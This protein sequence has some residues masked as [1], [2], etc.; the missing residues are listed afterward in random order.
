MGLPRAAPG[1]HP[2]GEAA[3]A[4]GEA[5]PADAMQQRAARA[6]V[7]RFADK[8]KHL[9]QRVLPRWVRV[10]RT[11]G[12]ST[13]TWRLSER[14]GPDFGPRHQERVLRRW[15]ARTL[16]I[17]VANIEKFLDWASE[18]RPGGDHG[19]F[20]D[21]A[22][23]VELLVRYV[24]DLLDGGAA[25]TMPG[26]RLQSLRFLD[27]AAGLAP[28][29][30]AGEVCVQHLALARAREAPA[31]AR[32]PT[33]YTAD[34]IR[35]LERAAATLRNP[36]DRVVIRTELRK[37]FAALRNDA[38]VWDKY[39]NWKQEGTADGGCLYGT[40][41]KTKATEATATR[42]RG[43]MPWIAPLRGIFQPPSGW[44]HGYSAD[45]KALGLSEDAEFAAKGIGLHSARRTI[46]TW[47]GSSGIFT[48]RELEVLG[49]HRSAGVGRVVCAC[50]VTVMA[51]PVSKLRQLLEHIVQGTFHPDAPAGMQWRDGARFAS[52]PAAPAPAAAPSRAEPV[53][54]ANAPA[55]ASAVGQAGTGTAPAPQPTPARSQAAAQLP[56]SAAPSAQVRSFRERGP[57]GNAAAH[58]A[59]QQEA[60]GALA[61]GA[62]TSPPAAAALLQRKERL[63]V[64]TPN[65]P[66]TNPCDFAV[67]QAKWSLQPPG[68]A[69]VICKV[70]RSRVSLELPAP[71]PA[72]PAAPPPGSIMAAF[73]EWIAELPQQVREHLA[74][75]GL[76]NA[77]LVVEG[78]QSSSGMH[79]DQCLWSNV[80]RNWC[81]FKLFALWPWTERHSIIDDAGKGTVFHLPLSERDVG[82]LRRAVKVALIRPG[83]VWVFS[84][85]QPHT[86]LCVGD[87]LSITAYESLVPAHPDAVAGCP[88]LGVCVCVW[89]DTVSALTAA[90]LSAR[91][92][93]LRCSPRGAWTGR[94]RENLWRVLEFPWG[95]EM[96]MFSSRFPFP[97]GLC[98]VRKTP[99]KNSGFLAC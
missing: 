94:L 97:L 81:G 69:C 1:R 28:P 36:L 25:P 18:E 7:L 86:A 3:G 46:F 74:T 63:V 78:Y 44:A 99:C 30:P 12:G 9:L 19:S 80:G 90:G 20:Q 34:Q 27:R 10:L 33:I 62:A 26:A 64:E 82:L 61:M 70:C 88:Q 65:G 60:T 32:L 50:N 77:A 84:G 75:A 5:R 38:A 92:I 47:A 17:H 71:A 4:V 29:L 54:P 40:A 52:Q 13:W 59:R 87:G 89:P 11:V 66:V 22:A 14:L 79:V 95:S 39:G 93:G 48:D 42:L 16:L 98:G 85:G 15:S 43:G 67:N 35:R 55:A 8:R 23:T 24:M 76:D 91:G 49:H 58:G 53:P 21:H 45:L 57:P 96:T 6:L 51:A 72:P 41:H 31:F 56:A 68:P 2:L 37:L 83:D 73:A